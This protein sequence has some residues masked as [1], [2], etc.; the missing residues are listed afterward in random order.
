LLVLGGSVLA[1]GLRRVQIP[2]WTVYVFLCGP[3]AWVGLLKAHVHPA[4]TL[5]FIVPFMGLVTFLAA[6]QAGSFEELR[7]YKNIDDT[8]ESEVR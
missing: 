4:L 3:V 6:V 1:L 5:V 2:H 7:R 8:I